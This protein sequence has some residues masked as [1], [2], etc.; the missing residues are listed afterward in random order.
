MS[1]KTPVLIFAGDDEYTLIHVPARI[2]DDKQ[3]VYQEVSTRLLHRIQEDFGQGAEL[4]MGE[5]P[6]IFYINVDKVIA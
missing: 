6:Q 2:Q 3:A 5:T 1:I 4:V